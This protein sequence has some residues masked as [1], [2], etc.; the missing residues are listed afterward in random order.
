MLCT[1]CFEEVTTTHTIGPSLLITHPVVLDHSYLQGKAH[2][3]CLSSSAAASA[4]T[5]QEQ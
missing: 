5:A 1:C 4:M 2:H 3:L